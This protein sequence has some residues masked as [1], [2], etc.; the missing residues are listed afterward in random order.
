MPLRSMTSLL[1]ELNAAIL[2]A[3]RV[4][5]LVLWLLAG[6]TGPKWSP[7]KP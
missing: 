7:L 1:S 2:N 4:I 5:P 3:S 6:L